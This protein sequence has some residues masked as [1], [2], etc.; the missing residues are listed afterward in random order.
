MPRFGYRRLIVLLQREGIPV[1]HKKAYRIYTEEDLKVRRKRKKIRSRVRTAPLPVPSRPNERWSVDFVQDCLSDGKR[2]QVLTIVDDFTRECPAVEVDTSIPGARVVRVL[3]RPTFTRGLPKVI[4]SDNGSEFTGKA[5]GAWAI[6]RGIKLHFIDPGRPIQ[7]AY[8]GCFNGKFRDECLD[9]N[10]FM[11]LADAKEKVESWRR[12][13]K[14]IRPHSSLN[15]DTP[16]GF[17]GRFQ[18][19]ITDEN[20]LVLLVQ[21][22]GAGHLASSFF[23]WL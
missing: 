17:A 22:R 13:Y 4:V 1:N 23:G 15:D 16:A 8:I 6:R 10:W 3:E 19:P 20:P 18:G 14:T 2:F 11:D 5:L 21:N 12:S 9:R 7:N